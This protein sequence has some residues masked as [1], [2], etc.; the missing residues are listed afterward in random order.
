[1]ASGRLLANGHRH[2]S[3]NRGQVP[4]SSHLVWGVVALQLC[5]PLVGNVVLP[6][7]TWHARL[8]LKSQY[9]PAPGLL[10]ASG[11]LRMYSKRFIVAWKLLTSSSVRAIVSATA[12]PE[13]KGAALISAASTTDETFSISA[14]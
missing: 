14:A 8:A 10:T 5:T 6:N 4:G 1:M 11:M 3:I 2:G 13:T 12:C 9:T 7:A